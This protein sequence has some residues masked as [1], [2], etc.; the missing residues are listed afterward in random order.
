MSVLENLLNEDNLVPNIKGAAFFILLY[1]HFED[2]VITAVKDAY[3]SDLIFDGKVFSEIDDEYI[4]LLKK[5][6]ENGEID[7][8]FSYESLYHNA[9]QKKNEYTKD[10]L[11]SAK[12]QKD[13]KR[14]HGSLIWLKNHQM[15]SEAELHRIHEIRKRR[16]DIVHKLFDV[17][18]K[19][20]T[21]DD[22]TMIAALLEYNQRIN[23][24]HFHIF[25][26]MVFGEDIPENAMIDDVLG[27][28]DA[29]LM[30]IFKILFC[31][32]GLSFKEELKK[33]KGL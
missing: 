26:A 33:V 16:N 19:G 3:S 29:V 10:V 20:L 23:K 7:E 27:Y 25:D 15:F 11:D 12:K 8:P 24:W 1:E 17:L 21:E 31:N 13:G 32:E 9:V 22:A 18:N 4:T 30:S 6:I 14:F 5:K 28:D 2:N